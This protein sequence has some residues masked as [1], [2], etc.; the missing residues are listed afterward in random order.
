MWYNLPGIR[1]NFHNV[2]RQRLYD[3][4]IQDCYAKIWESTRLSFLF[5]VK[6]IYKRS[7]YI[8]MIKNPEIRLTFTRLR[9]D[10]NIYSSYNVKK[11]IGTA[12]C[13]LSYNGEDSVTH[14]LLYCSTFSGERRTF[15]YTMLQNS[16]RW[17]QRND[18]D[19]LATVSDMRCPDSVVATCCNYIHNLYVSRVNQ[20]Y[21]TYVQFLLCKERLYRSFHVYRMKV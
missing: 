8:D 4:F 20:L 16:K 6:T 1:S 14:L 9:I 21:E 5:D 19:K 7:Q 18:R 2:F 3:Q 11:S 13:P 17:N 10:M 15:E 12:T